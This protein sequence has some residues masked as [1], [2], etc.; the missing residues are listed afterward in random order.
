MQ[1]VNQLLETH[2]DNFLSGGIDYFNN[3]TPEEFLEL[4]ETLTEAIRLEP[5]ETLTQ[6]YIS[7][8]YLYRIFLKYGKGIDNGISKLMGHT[9]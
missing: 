4:E 7:I 8:R 5:D 3:I 9:S 6:D 1:K 2:A